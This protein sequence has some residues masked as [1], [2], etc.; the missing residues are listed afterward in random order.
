MGFQT[1]LMQAVQF[2]IYIIIVI[3]MTVYL[4]WLRKVERGMS[5]EVTRNGKTFK[6]HLLKGLPR[7]DYCHGVYSWSNFYVHRCKPPTE[8]K[9]SEGLMRW[10]PDKAVE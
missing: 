8:I 3:A 2:D 7:C 4:T 6:Y 10:I 1:V 9:R 5:A